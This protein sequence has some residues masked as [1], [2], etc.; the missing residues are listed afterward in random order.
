MNKMIITFEGLDGVGKTSLIKYL[1]EFNNV[2][3]STLDNY[4]TITKKEIDSPLYSFHYYKENIEQKL[5]EIDRNNTNN[6]ILQDRY[7]GSVIGYYFLRRQKMPTIK[8]I[9]KIYDNFESSSVTFIFYTTFKNRKNRILSKKNICK[10]DFKSLKFNNIKF[11]NIFYN[12]LSYI[13]KNIFFIDTSRSIKE[14]A[15]NVSFILSKKSNIS[16]NI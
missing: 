6:I 7:I 12:K 9:Q 14:I 2:N 3:Y 16:L 5:L 11:W 15:N 4:F 10:Y 1:S 13:D 8:E